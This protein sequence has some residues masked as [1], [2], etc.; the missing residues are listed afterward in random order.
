MIKQLN[1]GQYRH[2]NSLIHLLDPR[3]KILSVLFLSILIFTI[4]GYEIL[5]FTIFVIILLILSKIDLMNLVFN[6]KVFYSF[7]LFMLIMYLLFARNQIQDGLLVIWRFFMVILL[8][9]VLTYSTTLS[10]L[11]AAVEKL[12]IPL[13]LFGVKPRN[14]G[15]LI[16]ATIRFIPVMFVNASRAKDA[17]NSRLGSFKEVKTVKIFMVLLLE[18]MLKS[19]SNL[20][21]AMYSRLYN[22]DAKSSLALS[23]G[24]YDY[25][26]VTSILILA[27][28][29]IIY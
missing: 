23:M 16:S 26:S 14:I 25:I 12:A 21:D 2:K 10:M 27:L 29:L 11:I 9:Y 5:I 8:S 28:I 4:S 18:R 13:S 17:I 1:F 6:L 19:A 22:E 20:A 3:V 24:K 15:V 7:M